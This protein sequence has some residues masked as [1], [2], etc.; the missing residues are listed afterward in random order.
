MLYNIQNLFLTEEEFNK[1]VDMLGAFFK[2]LRWYFRFKR[3]VDHNVK[4]LFPIMMWIMCS[5]LCSAPLH[6]T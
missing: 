2:Q 5:T 6:Y 1:Y 4:A 3:S